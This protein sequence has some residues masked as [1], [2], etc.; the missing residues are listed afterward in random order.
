MTAATPAE[1]APFVAAHGAAQVLFAV[2][3]G[4][5]VVGELRQALPGRLPARPADVPAEVLFRVVFFVGI[6]VIPLARAVA[7][8]AAFGSG[9]WP[10]LVGM[11]VG[12]VGLLLRWW[13]F[14]TLGTW[15]TVVLGVGEDQ[16]VVDRG[17]YRFVR[18][19]AYTGL[20][21]ALLGAGLVYQNWVGAAGA[22][23][24]VLAA[25]VHRI[26]I[27]ER[28][29]ENTLGDRYREYAATRARL[30]PHLW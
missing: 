11:A 10:Y 25:L 28:A 29:L 16:P 3:V 24:V 20:L 6:L 13:A 1:L 30:V 15:F 17:P 23:L 4:A 12:W 27:E 5:F 2:S 9:V 26:L 7:P 8:D 18:H 14:A 22:V 19:P 21:L